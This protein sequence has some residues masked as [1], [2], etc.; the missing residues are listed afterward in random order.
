[1]MMDSKKKQLSS[2]GSRPVNS[3]LSLAVCVTTFAVI[4]V[5]YVN[6]NVD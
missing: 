2:G 6:L 4:K 5:S 3:K 1:M